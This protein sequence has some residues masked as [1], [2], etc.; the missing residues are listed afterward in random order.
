MYILNITLNIDDS[1]HSSCLEWLKSALPSFLV[2]NGL[3]N[4]FSIL[5]VMSEETQ[6]GS[7]Y[8]LQFHLSNLEKFPLFEEAYNNVIATGLYT[9]FQD[10]VLD[11]R[12]TL[13]RVN[14]EL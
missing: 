8:S 10:K 1:V 2:E 12:S 4:D 14:W 7:T 9:N 6:N 11:F 3:S 13:K 5:Q